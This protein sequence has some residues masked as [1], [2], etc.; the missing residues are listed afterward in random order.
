MESWKFQAIRR[1]DADYEKARCSS[2]W[3]GRVPDRYPALIVY[4]ETE[5]D[6]QAIVVY[7]KENNMSIGTKSGGHSWTASF[8]RDG[9][10]MV[11]M[12][13]MNKFQFDVKSRTA[14]VQPAAY[15]SDLNA[16]LEKHDL[17]FPGG[18]C[19]TVGMGG[20]LLQGGFGWNSRKWGLACESVLAI[21][22]VN[23]DGNLIHA[24][25][26]DNSDFYWAARGAGC[27]YF[28]L[29]TRFYLKLYPMPK[30]ILTARYVFER[31]V[32][33]EVTLAVERISDKVSEDLEIGIFVAYDQDGFNGRCTV[34]L[35]LDALSDTAEEAYQA[36]KLIHELPIVQEKSIKSYPY[37]SCTL[38]DM[39]QRFDDILDNKGR[40]YET[41]NMWTDAPV[42]NL[43]GSMNEIIDNL[44]PAPSHLYLLWWLPVHN[45][46]DMAFSM[47]AQLYVALYAISTDSGYDARNSTYVVNSLTR[48]EP[49][50]KGIQLADENLP[51]HPGK[52]MRTQN[53]VR[54]EKLRQKHDPQGRFYSYM[55]LP[56]EFMTS[57]VSL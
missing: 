46:P 33:D 43:L 50:R 28:G 10:I 54:L 19:P 22:V 5:Q 52:F 6:V 16:A 29:V 47:E 23:A 42:Q 40:R 44:P 21:D 27:G 14:E 38:K 39:L 9:G 11:D 55:R 37:V 1:N 30:G 48:M 2:V 49:F 45:R 51:S 25:A 8:L 36:L 7:A 34:A 13:R 31:D 17:I 12:I 57:L 18:H 20:F 26:T 15:G 24:S 56:V 53:Y 32:F 41:N 35:T 4:P 3:N